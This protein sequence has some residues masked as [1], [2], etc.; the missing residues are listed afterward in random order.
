MDP[1]LLIIIIIIILLLFLCV[2]R[3][4]DLTN[5]LFRIRKR[6]DNLLRGRGELNLEELLA[7]QA[8]D[9]EVA[10]ELVESIKIENEEL[11][12]NI[13]QKS[14]VLTKQ[15]EGNIK[16]VDARL[17]DSFKHFNHDI[18]ERLVKLEKS[19]AEANQILSKKLD[20]SISN[21]TSKLDDKTDE[22]TNEINRKINL[23]SDSVSLAIQRVALRR[24][25][26]LENQAGELSF[27][28]VMLNQYN[29]GI[30]LTTING[31]DSSYTYSK[32]IKNG[33]TELECSE[34]EQKT[35]DEALNIRG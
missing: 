30:M 6:Y 16:E 24:Y 32:N 18:N 17:S 22:F 29:S 4:T 3:I 15:V 9:I 8:L 14:N 20:S 28:L 27:T 34:E 10:K 5:K 1:I 19:H 11:N 26:A 21:L 33:K 2:Y 31:R 23:I 25:N 35:L 12:R 13:N 7:A